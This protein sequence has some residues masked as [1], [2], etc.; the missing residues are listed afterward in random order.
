MTCHLLDSQGPLGRSM[1]ND[2]NSP[3]YINY[4]NVDHRTILYI[5]FKGVKYSLGKRDA[6]I[7]DLPVR[8][9]KSKPRWDQ[10]KLAVGD[11]FSSTTYYKVKDITDE[12]NVQV[13]NSHHGK[14]SEIKMS[15]DILEYDMS[16]GKAYEEEKTVCR[17]DVVDLITS[18]KETVM[19]VKFRKKVDN[20]HVKDILKK[21]TKK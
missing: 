5:I 10:S 8:V 4:R 20:A 13:I 7:T 3:G 21:I 14:N 19:T 2:L 17:S 16:S 12:E 1:V 9:D 15:R 18:A 11:W 6:D